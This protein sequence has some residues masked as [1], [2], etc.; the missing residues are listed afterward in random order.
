MQ[1]FQQQ[2]MQLFQKKYPDFYQS[3]FINLDFH[4]IPHFG[5]QS[6]MEKVW[7]GARGKAIKGANTL[8]AQDNQS[9]TII[10][11]SV[12]VSVFYYL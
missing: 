11:A 7:C 1:E 6:Q 5:E 8:F 10:A 4:S 2:L 12:S 9:N 3:N